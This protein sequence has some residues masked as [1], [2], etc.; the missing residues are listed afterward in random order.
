MHLRPTGNFMSYMPDPQGIIAP[1]RWKYNRRMLQK[2]AEAAAAVD[3]SKSSPSSQSPGVPPNAS[4][5]PV[6]STTGRS[7]TPGDDR[8]IIRMPQAVS[9]SR[10]YVHDLMSM[11]QSPVAGP[12]HD[13]IGAAAAAAYHYHATHGPP[14][15]TSSSQPQSPAQSQ[16][17]HGGPSPV[18]MQNH[19]F[20]GL[21]YVKNR[22]VEAMRT[23][24]DH[25][26]NNEETHSGSNDHRGSKDTQSPHETTRKTPNQYEER[27]SRARSAYASNNDGHHVSQSMVYQQPA[28]TYP[29]SV[30]NVHAGLAP[31]PHMTISHQ[32]P[33]SGVH[34]GKQSS[35]AHS[36]VDLSNSS[37][38]S[39]ASGHA[40]GSGNANSTAE[41]K[42]L[43][44]S[45]YEA[46]S[47]ED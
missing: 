14:P 42:P 28:Y 26:G 27:D 37:T 34:H 30:L 45:Q 32:V 47:D 29:Y 4:P 24:N 21:K 15:P 2:E 11:H 9:P 10:K 3:R 7:S 23:E 25:T 20:D 40:V 12:S 1:D 36:H 13:A 38:G 31:P 5:G 33:P 35:S 18:A 17:V 44:S 8:N 19:Q 22:I 43:L 6:G 39:N 41:P 16:R 46:L